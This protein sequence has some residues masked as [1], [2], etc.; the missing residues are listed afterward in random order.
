MSTVRVYARCKSG[1]RNYL[2][3]EFEGTRDQ[4][5]EH[6]KA[7]TL[8]GQPTHF[9]EVSSLDMLAATKKYC[10]GARFDPVTCTYYD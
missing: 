5:K 8:R 10:D 9:L 7:R 2:T 3:V 1:R 6:V 4:C